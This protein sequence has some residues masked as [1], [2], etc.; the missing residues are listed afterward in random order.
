MEAH[1]EP[2]RVVVAHLTHPRGNRGE[3]CAISLTDH[4]ERFEQL[5]AV[6]VGGSEYVVERVWYHKDQPVFQ[7]RGID[8]IDAA[9]RLAGQDVT[10]PASE[11]FPLPEDEY[12]FA[13]LVGCR[14]I[15]TGTGHL[16]GAVTGWQE[17]GGPVLLEVDGGRI[18]IP[19][20]KAI[21]TRIDVPAREIRAAL[22]EGLVELNA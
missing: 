16:V 12:Y 6:T 1:P 14:V 17:S 19:F 5:A 18:L 4:P 2:E 9:E 11:R 21:L 8:S 22:P 20:V 7:F 3:L 13:D 15:D 10:I